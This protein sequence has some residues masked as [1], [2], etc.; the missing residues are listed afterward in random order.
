MTGVAFEIFGI[1]IYWY[2]II[3]ATAVV[4]G[5]YIAMKEAE[6]LGHNSELILDFCLIAIP[7]SI[8]GARI[9]YVIFKWAYY[10]QHPQDIIKIWHGGLAIYGGVIAGIIVAI[11][12]SRRRKISLWELV[13]ILTPSLI[14]GQAMGR[15]GNFFN[16]E[17][18]GYQVTNPSLQWFPFAVKIGEN[19]HLA[20]FFYESIWDFGV[21]FYLIWL[22]K[23][24]KMKGSVFLAYLILYPLGRFFIEPLRTDSL[25]FGPFR[26]SQLLSLILIIIALIIFFIKKRYHHS[27]DEQTEA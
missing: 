1:S 13:D 15:W 11:F 5:L 26:V 18:Y 16:Q 22:R 21:F 24:K 17:A 12:F 25:M 23:R 2:G 4:I 10:S 14:L 9:Y 3:I 27:K 20:T 19:W 8:L 7:L 6:R